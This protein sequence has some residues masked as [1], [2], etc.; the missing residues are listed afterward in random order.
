MGREIRTDTE[1]T[2][3]LITASE[4][5]HRRDPTVSSPLIEVKIRKYS[6]N[7]MI[8]SMYATVLGYEMS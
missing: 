4:L 8:L 3:R 5:M 6:D 1:F 7:T 2:A